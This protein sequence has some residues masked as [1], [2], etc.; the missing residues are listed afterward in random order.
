MCDQAILDLD[1]VAAYCDVH[2]KVNQ[3]IIESWF[4]FFKSIAESTD[5]NRIGGGNN[6]S[7]ETDSVVGQFVQ[8][9][10]KIE[11]VVEESREMIH[12]SP[13]PDETPQEIFSRWNVVYEQTITTS[14][15]LTVKPFGLLKATPVIADVLKYFRYFRADM[16][17][18]VVIATVPMQYG[19]LFFTEMPYRSLTQS[20]AL[21]HDPVALDIAELEEVGFTI[22]W[23]CPLD[24]YDT[25]GLVTSVDNSFVVHCVAPMDISSTDT[26]TSPSVDLT[27]FARFVNPQVAGPIGRDLVKERKNASK[28]SARMCVEAHAFRSENIAR[29]VGAVAVG[30]IT[31]GSYASSLFNTATEVIKSANEVQDAIKGNVTAG[32]G[33]TPTAIMRQ[34]TFGDNVMWPSVVSCPGL[35]W[36][37]EFPGP[38]ENKEH[39][40]LDYLSV[41]SYVNLAAFTLSDQYQILTAHPYYKSDVVTTRLCS[42]AQCARF[43]RGSI[44]FHLC[45]IT[46]PFIT[47][48]FT[49]Y[50]KLAP[51]VSNVSNI[52]FANITVRGTTWVT[53]VVPYIS[54]RPWQ[55]TESGLTVGYYS[56]VLLNCDAIKG[57]GSG[58]TSIKLMI[59]NS[60]GPDFRLRSPCCPAQEDA[61]EAHSVS[62]LSKNELWLGDAVPIKDYAT[63][64]VSFEQLMKLTSSRDTVI[65]PTFTPTTWTAGLA[66][67]M[68]LFDY[69]ANHFVFYSGGVR[70]K[71]QMSD[72]TKVALVTSDPRK[73]LGSGITLEERYGSG[74]Q[75]YDLTVNGVIET[76]NPYLNTLPFLP[77]GYNTSG[78]TETNPYYPQIYTPGA[79]SGVSFCTVSAGS[80]FRVMY[81]SPPP[82]LYRPTVPTVPLAVA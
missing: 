26:G 21:S 74:S 75:M 57:S 41:P 20:E 33:N 70:H 28:A 61:V 47:G 51:D 3:L 69:L 38:D 76:E 52:P 63:D 8:N 46:S 64:M 68:D 66:P 24:Y 43:W 5:H 54:T 71:V 35:N 81:M 10:N 78:I 17:I 25:L 80:T 16:E 37:A 39:S 11:Q 62:T 79:L 15:H 72:G 30:A 34:S 23:R 82:S 36:N 4:I 19:I 77:Y 73:P 13:F 55:T 40:L 48:R 14:T 42:L 32:E 22:P 67:S 45:F 12:I 9:E 65:G 49:A 6:T 31:V 27:Y 29:T 44:R 7:I 1:I 50:L 60:A 18:K 2:F 59:W 56:T 58:V 53:L